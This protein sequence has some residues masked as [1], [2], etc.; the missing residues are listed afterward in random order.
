MPQHC[1]KKKNQIEKQSPP[2]FSFDFKSI[3]KAKRM[4][5]DQASKIINIHYNLNAEMST[6]IYAFLC[7]N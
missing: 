2:K 5:H 1:P 7:N 3:G 6:D 4:Q